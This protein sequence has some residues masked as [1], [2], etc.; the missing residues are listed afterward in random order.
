MSTTTTTP[1]PP[2]PSFPPPTPLLLYILPTLLS[3]P[4]LLWLLLYRYHP[5]HHQQILTYQRTQISNFLQYLKVDHSPEFED[6]YWLQQYGAFLGISV[7]VGLIVASS[8]AWIIEGQGEFALRIVPPFLIPFIP[9]YFYYIKV[10]SNSVQLS[11]VQWCSMSLCLMNVLFSGIVVRKANEEG[12]GVSIEILKRNLFL[13]ALSNVVMYESLEDSLV[14]LFTIACGSS[15]GCAIQG[16]PVIPIMNQF[17]SLAGITILFTITSARGRMNHIVNKLIHSTPRNHD[18]SIKFYVIAM[19]TSLLFIAMWATTIEPQSL[20]S[21][22]RNIAMAIHIPIA[23]LVW[24]GAPAVETSAPMSTTT[25]MLLST[26]PS[27]Q[28]EVHQLFVDSLPSLIQVIVTIMF[29]IGAAVTTT[30]NKSTSTT[31]TNNQQSTLHHFIDDHLKT[32]LQLHGGLMM[33]ESMFGSS[34]TTTTTTNDNSTEKSIV[35]FISVIVI[36]FALYRVYRLNDFAMQNTSTYIDEVVLLPAAAAA[37]ASASSNSSHSKK[38]SSLRYN[39]T[40]ARI[41]GLLAALVQ[42]FAL[43][44]LNV[45]DSTILLMGIMRILVLGMGRSMPFFDLCVMSLV[46]S[47]S[48]VI[49]S[50]SPY[51]VLNSLG[52]SSLHL[53]MALESSLT[54]RSIAILI[55]TNIDAQRFVE[56][57]LKQKFIGCLDAVDDLLK[58]TNN[59]LTDEQRTLLKKVIRTCAFGLDQTL[60]YTL[61]RRFARVGDIGGHREFKTLQAIV[62]DW[63]LTWADEIEWKKSSN[64][65]D[66]SVKYA[67]CKRWDLVRLVLHKLLGQNLTNI[68]VVYSLKGDEFSNDGS[69]INKAHMEF[70][71]SRKGRKPGSKSRFIRSSSSGGGNMEQQ[72][73]DS[74]FNTNNRQRNLLEPVIIKEMHAICELRKQG[75]EIF[76]SFELQKESL[77]L[78]PLTREEEQQQEDGTTTTT[79]HT[80]TATVVDSISPILRTTT[81]ISS[82]TSAASITTTTSSYNTDE[83]ISQQQQ[84]HP[85]QSIQQQPTTLVVPPGLIF[86]VLDDVK[87]VR[88]NVLRYLLD[89]FQASNESFAM[90]STKHE[91][92]IDFVERCIQN[93]VDVVLLDIHLEYEEELILGTQ[94]AI[95]LRKRGFKNTIM[96]HSANEQSIALQHSANNSAIE[97]AIDGYVEKRAFQ[98]DYLNMCIVNAM[99]VNR[100]KNKHTGNIIINT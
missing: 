91:S 42:L 84:Q 76:L 21:M 16:L 24:R 87:L 73:S 92:T 46:L 32:M 89:E 30:S 27:N 19:T 55:Q 43:F 34:T 18:S 72:Q 10:A 23:L 5:T 85:I 49:V 36:V 65:N 52:L 12:L 93:S 57:S 58:D 1:L 45:S 99:K 3:L 95:D 63:Q 98:K 100:G 17:L 70:L 97:N 81:L 29:M 69:E 51:T 20:S 54:R 83:D 22:L 28:R 9:I 25:T 40:T 94:I 35:S 11:V 37:S 68:I 26:T 7:S 75:Y 79:T 74:S 66:L 82:S 71:I 44:V 61:K 39:N 48:S 13:R 88:L 56:H 2:P 50:K 77:Q 47:L 96:L 59:G 53:L 90:G 31:T 64:E 6:Q 8:V 60:Y 78:L 86:A 15:I 38:S 33:I 67:I 41:I 62:T 80:A 14:A 4:S